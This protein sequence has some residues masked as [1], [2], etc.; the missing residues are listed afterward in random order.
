[1]TVKWLEWHTVNW[2]PLH[3]NMQSMVS[4]AVHT[5]YAQ[6]QLGTPRQSGCGHGYEG[7]LYKDCREILFSAIITWGK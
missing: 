3:L 7:R 1:M 2:P 6:N 5:A 4:F